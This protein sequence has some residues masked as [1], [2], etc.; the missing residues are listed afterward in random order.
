MKSLLVPLDWEEI[1]L[2]V[3]KE[4]IAVGAV[5]SND[6]SGEGPGFRFILAGIPAMLIAEITREDFMQRITTAGLERKGFETIPAAA[7]FY[8]LSTD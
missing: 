6:Q 3:A 2:L 7:R 1:P 8:T 4:M 5:P